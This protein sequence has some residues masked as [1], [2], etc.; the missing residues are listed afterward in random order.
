MGGGAGTTI[1]IKSYHTLVSTLS[2]ACPKNLPN[3]LDKSITLLKAI[4][5]SH[6]FAFMHYWCLTCLN[7]YPKLCHWTK[8]FVKKLRQVT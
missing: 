3:F 4:P 1:A 8:F 2:R 7:T 6:E 5:L